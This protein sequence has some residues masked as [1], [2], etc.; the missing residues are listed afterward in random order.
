MLPIGLVQS[1]FALDAPIRFGGGL[2]HGGVLNYGNAFAHVLA[3]IHVAPLFHME[4]DLAMPIG[5]SGLAGNTGQ[6]L[7]GLDCEG[8]I[9]ALGRQPPTC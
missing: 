5:R 8:L 2:G 1:C 9:E 4:I 7:A 3:E 6:Y